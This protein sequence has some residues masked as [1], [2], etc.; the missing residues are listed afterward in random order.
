MLRR[1]AACA[2]AV[3]LCLPVSVASAR[4]PLKRAD[5]KTIRADARSK[6]RVFADEY[7]AVLPSVACRKTS[8][9]SARC[10]IRL[11][12]LRTHPGGCTITL[13]YVVTRT[14]QIEGSLA[15]DRCG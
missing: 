1:L 15:R 3:S 12:G 6:A 2:A 11:V 8:P 14:R 4:S 13:V 9:Y 7:G 10:T 5:M